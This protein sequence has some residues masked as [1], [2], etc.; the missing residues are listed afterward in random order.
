M[1]CIT[2]VAVF[3]DADVNLSAIDQSLS[4][5]FGLHAL[6]LCQKSLTQETRGRESGEGRS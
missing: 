3:V 1:A 4:G 2:V 5:I 6:K